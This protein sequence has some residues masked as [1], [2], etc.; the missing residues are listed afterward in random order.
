MI[1]FPGHVP[2]C[3]CAACKAY[4]DAYFADDPDAE[5]LPEDDEQ[6]KLAEQFKPTGIAHLLA[7]LFPAEEDYPKQNP[8]GSW[9]HLFQP[10]T[11]P[12]PER[13]RKRK[14]SQ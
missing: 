4:W 2:T 5:P 7:A 3:D 12:K 6:I 1:S 11:P 14:S 8:D 13:R 10:A 9:T